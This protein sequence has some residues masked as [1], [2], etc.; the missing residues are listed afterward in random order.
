MYTAFCV[1]CDKAVILGSNVSKGQT[2]TCPDCSTLLE[3]I[4]LDPPELDWAYLEQAVN[5]ES[6]EWDD[7][8]DESSEQEEAAPWLYS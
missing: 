1:C 7:E 2:T 5:E 4:S 8:Y 3:V 6:L